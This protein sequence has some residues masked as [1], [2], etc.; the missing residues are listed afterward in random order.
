MIV[1][2]ETTISQDL[3]SAYFIHLCPEQCLGLYYRTHLTELLLQMAELFK[4]LRDQRASCIQ[5]E[6]Q[7]VFIILSVLDYIKV[8]YSIPSTNNEAAMIRVLQICS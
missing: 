3:P 2:G 5:V 7:F 6:G 1:V 8:L 4:T